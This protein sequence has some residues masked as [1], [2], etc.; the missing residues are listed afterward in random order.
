MSEER[1]HWT[2]FALCVAGAALLLLCGWLV[3]MHLRG[4][5]AAVIE[6]AGAN[7]TSLIDRGL[8]LAHASHRESARLIWE[9]ATNQHVPGAGEI[10]SALSVSGISNAPGEPA[11]EYV[12][13]TEN[14]ERLLEAL[15]ASRSA[16][17]RE[18]YRCRQLTNTVLFPPSSSAAGQ[19]FD[20]AVAVCGRLLEE[21]GLTA[22]LRNQISSRAASAN[23]GGS[24]QPMEEVLMDMLSLG[25]RFSWDE[26]GV[27]VSQ[28]DD[29]ATLDQ[30]ATQARNAGEQLPVLFAAVDLSQ[31]PAAVAG[32][33]NNYSQSGLGDLGAALRCGAGGVD[34]LTRRNQRFYA[35]DFRRRVGG[36]APCAVFYRGAKDLALRE[37]WIALTV[38]W[39][40]YISCG[41]LLALAA[42]YVMPASVRLEEPLRVRGI[43]LAREMLFALGFLLVVLLVSEPFLAQESQKGQ[44]A[45]R[46]QLP[47]V[48]AA[49]A[50]ATANAKAKLMNPPSL[51]TL[52]LFFVLQALIYCA[53]LVKLAEIRRQKVVPRIRLKLLENE[54]HLF[55]AGLYLGF[56]GTIVSLI[57]V[58]LGIIQ[59]SL[60]AA[61]SSTSFGII[62]C[63]IFKIFHLRPARR[64]LLLQAE[65]EA[66]ATESPA[67]AAVSLA[68][69]A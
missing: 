67:T 42:H 45:I 36:A 16:A 12:I 26:L 11:T 25:K 14:R 35:T 19:A 20:A 5:D 27:F 44:I 46:L 69:S 47:G 53:C 8:A 4:V 49:A 41:F 57:L 55:D 50:S 62:F 6:G 30:L 10:I 65:E 63:S 64:Q 21:N 32:Y 29:V 28:I 23:G 52:L 56:V 24:S 33:L 60:M 59:P 13:R 1:N 38:K 18:L 22:G 58:S 40:F 43:H 9:A 48:G 54:D 66:S 68:T 34:E 15:A 3:P 37:P 31:K 17:A 7:T 2:G 39:F 51:L 61:Y